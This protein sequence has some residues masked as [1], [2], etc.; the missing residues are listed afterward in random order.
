M[1]LHESNV[2]RTIHNIEKILVKSGCFSLPGKK[3]LN[4]Q[5]LSETS[6]LTIV[7]DVTETE[8]ERPKKKQKKLQW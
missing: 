5:A 4:P 6:P 8:I 2:C 7:I 3:A 1:N